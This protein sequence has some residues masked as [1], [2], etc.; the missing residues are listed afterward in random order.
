MSNN[1]LHLNLKKQW[2]DMI[3]DGQKKEEYREIKP[4]WTKRI[5]ER[6][7][8]DDR[9]ETITFSNGYSKDRR[10]MVV[11]FKSL[12]QHCGLPEWGAEYDVK[13]YVLGLGK[14][15]S[16]TNCELLSK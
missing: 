9:Q 6:W 11:E 5:L 1:T 4:F 15:I 8:N 14:I 13:Y 12:D 16:T 7:E 2:F 10:Q 3:L